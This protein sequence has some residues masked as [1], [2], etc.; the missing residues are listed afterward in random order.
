MK[1]LPDKSIDLIVV[2]FAIEA[3]MG[4]L[5]W[6]SARIRYLI[7]GRLLPKFVGSVPSS[8]FICMPMWTS[9]ELKTVCG[10]EP[11]RWFT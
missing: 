4:P 8:S 5:K 1:L 6:F 3:G 9:V 10:T 7:F 11:E 2:A